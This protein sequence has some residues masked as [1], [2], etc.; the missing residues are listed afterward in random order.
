MLKIRIEDVRG[1]MSEYALPNNFKEQMAKQVKEQIL[2]QTY[3]K[4]VEQANRSLKSSKQQ[5]IDGLRM[6]ED[7]IELT[8]WL[9]N[10]IESG[11]SGFDMKAGFANSSKKKLTKDGGW[12]LTIPFGIK[13]P[14]PRYQN[15]MTWQI[16]R[17]VRAGR[18]YDP[19]QRQTRSAFSV[20][21]TGKVFDAYQHKSPILQGIQQNT[22][23]TGGNSSYNTF[24]RVSSKSSSN[25]WIHTGIM[26]HQLFD[27][28][29]TDVDVEAIIDNVIND[30]I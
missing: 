18:N 15:S 2:S 27:K 1:V 28:A 6:L 20:L 10:S 14:S 19:G 30:G 25:S 8:G 13:T 4:I 12:Y 3:L 5:Y 17:A 11:V 23:P 9:P 21:S 16:Y 7:A 29:W 22:S 24:R 26:A